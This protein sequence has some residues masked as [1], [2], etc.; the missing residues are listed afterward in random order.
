METSLN[1]SWREVNKDGIS[2]TLLDLSLNI[3][4]DNK[5]KTPLSQCRNSDI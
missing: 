3:P 5:L 1:I 4:S 2:L